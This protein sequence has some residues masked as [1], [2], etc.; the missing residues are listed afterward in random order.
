MANYNLARS[1]SSP[2]QTRHNGSRKYS[3]SIPYQRLEKL[4]NKIYSHYVPKPIPKTFDPPLNM[5]QFDWYNPIQ[6]KDLRLSSHKLMLQMLKWDGPTKEAQPD[7]PFFCRFPRFLALTFAQLFQ[8]VSGFLDPPYQN[9]CAIVFPKIPTALYFDLDFDFNKQQEQLFEIKTEP[10]TLRY[11]LQQW[12]SETS[13]DAEAARRAIQETVAEALYQSVFRCMRAIATD[14]NEA[15][16]LTESAQCVMF[17]ASTANKISLHCHWNVGCQDV[18]ALKRFAHIHQSTYQQQSEFEGLQLLIDTSVYT[19]HRAMRIIGSAKPERQSLQQLIV[20]NKPWG[21]ERPLEE[22]LYFSFPNQAVDPNLII[23]I[24]QHTV[25]L[26]R[27][28]NPKSSIQLPKH[29]KKNDSCTQNM[30]VPSNIEA[31]IREAIP[32]PGLDG[33]RPAIHKI[34]YQQKWVKNPIDSQQLPILRR[35]YLVSTTAK[36]PCI[37]RAMKLDM[38]NVT[39]RQI[40]IH[41]RETA[42]HQHNHTYYMIT[43]Q[44]ITAYCHDEQCIVDRQSIEPD[45]IRLGLSKE[46]SQILFPA[47]KYTEYEQIQALCELE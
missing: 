25:Q 8:V 46:H 11:V 30:T 1:F 39:T 29:P 15:K 17:T 43:P 19:K 38:W 32:F 10:G 22:L 34:N 28:T 20:H 31:L 26:S 6:L 13:E 23:Q 47:T 42:V 36:E 12:S 37:F 40:Q 3:L 41:A 14:Q 21:K 24:G 4:A 45:M 5:T 9:F 2:P 27:R 35:W 18:D 44:Y 7:D 33:Y 16:K